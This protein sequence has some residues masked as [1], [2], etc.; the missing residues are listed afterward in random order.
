MS[1]ID[2]LEPQW[3]DLCD[4]AA[5]DV[6]FCRPEFIRAWLRAFEPDANL[7]IAAAQR[8]HNLDGLLPL[9]QKNGLVCGVPA[10]I[11]QGTANAH[12]CR[13][14]LVRARGEAGDAA[15]AG[16]WELLK[17]TS[18]WD[19][20]ELPLVPEGGAG[21]RLTELASRDGYPTGLFESDRSAW[22][23]LRPGD[24][25]ES[26]PHD[27]HFRQNLRRRMRKA[28]AAHE[29]QLDRVTAPDAAALA[30]FYDLERS[31]W[32]GKRKTAIADSESTRRFYDELAFAAAGE[33]YFSLYLLDFDGKAAAGHFGLSYRG[34]YYSPKVAYDESLANLGP[35]HLIVQSI[36]DDLLGR[37]YSE[38]DFVGPWMDWKAEWA[39]GE[40]R[41][42]YCYIFQPTALG[43][44]LHWM[45]FR[46]R[47]VVR[48][49]YHRLR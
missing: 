5:D 29:V 38:F 39:R 37:Q 47:P 34:K 7:L 3:R 16:I 31:G 27:A 33:G 49:W 44:L 25:G 4:A 17:K 43:R 23:A 1:L 20:L 12:S 21:E 36:L 6:P 24:T 46:V 32:K 28:R 22:I 19:M 9:V 18:G 15:I 48:S 13:F 40:R 10:R 14:D 26:I 45:R 8:G 41:H 2:D 11:L 35:G 42:N 30:R